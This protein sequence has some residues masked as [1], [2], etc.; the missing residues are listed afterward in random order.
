MSRRKRLLSIGVSVLLALPVL[1]AGALYLRARAAVPELSGQAHVAGLLASVE[2]VRDSH[3]IPHIYARSEADAYFGLGYAHGQDRFTQME[4]SRRLASGRLAELIG[5]RALDSD[6]LFRTLG[7]SRVAEANY[8]ALDDV[9][10]SALNA[11]TRGVNAWLEAGDPLPIELALLAAEPEPWRAQDSLT[12][13]KLM[14]AAAR[15][16]ALARAARGVRAVCRRSHAD[17]L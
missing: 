7:L 9:T 1:A 17:R 11:Y 2:I 5:A 10:R 15:R 13:L 4:L 12:V 3:A 8:A 6:R 14:A 16:A